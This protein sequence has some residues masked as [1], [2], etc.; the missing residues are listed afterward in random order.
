ME[1]PLTFDTE[2]FELLHDDVSH[3]DAIKA[4]EQRS[5]T[6]DIQELSKEITTLAKP[7]RFA[8]TDMYAWRELFDL[9]LQAAVFFSTHE[10]HAGSRTPA[11]AAKQL[12]WFQNEVTRKEL[13][14]SFK[15]PASHRALDQFV[16]INIELLRNMRFQEI[17]QLAIGKILKSEYPAARL[18]HELSVY[19]IR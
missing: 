15:L 5:L 12:E 16:K 19:R 2:F 18:E 4:E 1:I 9:Y 14:A 7:T 17:N 8:K 13:V 6:R 10:A 11:S 3:L